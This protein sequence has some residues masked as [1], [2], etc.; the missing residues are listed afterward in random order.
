MKI[1]NSHKV[2]L[3]KLAR[4]K[5]DSCN[6]P[7]NFDLRTGTGPARVLAYKKSITHL[8]QSILSFIIKV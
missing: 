5:A 8:S 1:A 4:E 2:V 7:K 6:S 3:V